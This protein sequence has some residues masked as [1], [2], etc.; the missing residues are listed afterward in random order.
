MTLPSAPASRPMISVAPV[1]RSRTSS[2]VH[3]PAGDRVAERSTVVALAVAVGDPHHDER[4]VRQGHG[5][6]RHADGDRNSVSRS[7]VV[8]SHGPPRGTIDRQD[9]AGAA[10]WSIQTAI[11]LPSASVAT[12]GS[13]KDGN[14]DGSGSR[15]S[16]CGRH[17]RG[18]DRTAGARPRGARP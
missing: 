17:R 7:I 6:R 1:R 11:E 14:D 8:V 16:H 9:L 4:A 2:V 10:S 3:A 15:G 13:T 5:A 18:R 12:A